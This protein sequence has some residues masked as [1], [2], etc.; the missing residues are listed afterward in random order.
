MNYNNTKN[1]IRN[2]F[3]RSH[4]DEKHLLRLKENEKLIDKRI[5]F[6]CYY[7]IRKPIIFTTG[8]IGLSDPILFE[9]NTNEEQSTKTYRLS[10]ILE[11]FPIRWI[12]FINV[13]VIV[14]DA[15]WNGTAD[16]V[17]RRSGLFFYGQ[18]LNLISESNFISVRKTTQLVYNFVI[19][20]ENT[21]SKIKINIAIS[22]PLDIS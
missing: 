18:D 9:N 16:F 6:N 3:N 21:I 1:K 19:P 7:T 2:I 13:Y 20:T 10:T 5:Q 12:P 8:W 22:N 15:F 14:D 4:I 17:I 11:N